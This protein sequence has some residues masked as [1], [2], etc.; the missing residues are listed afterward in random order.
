MRH[1]FR[2]LEIGG[3]YGVSP[4]I[5]LEAP[6]WGPKGLEHTHAWCCVNAHTHLAWDSTQGPPG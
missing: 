4:S 6:V 3:G 2:T 1:G 5:V